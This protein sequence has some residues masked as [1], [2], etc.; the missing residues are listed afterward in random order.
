[1]EKLTVKEAIAQGYTKYGY[2][3]KEWQHAHDLDD[4][5]GNHLSDDS[6]EDLVLF[7]KESKSSTI[8]ER[9]IAD[10]LSDYIGEHDSEA[11]ARDDDRVYD[12]ILKMDF[13]ETAAKI[14]KELEQHN[15]YMLTNIKLIK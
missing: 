2:S 8:D 7:E 5:L 12:A 6:W 14:N 4:I 3:N 13:S 9:Q 15:Y 10:L 11:C 1:M